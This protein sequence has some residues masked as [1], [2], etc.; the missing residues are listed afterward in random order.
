MLFTIAQAHAVAL[1]RLSVFRQEAFFLCRDFQLSDCEQT[2]D[3][4]AVQYGIYGRFDCSFER[5]NVSLFRPLV[6]ALA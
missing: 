3:E 5:Q 4:K 1:N 2:C 6:G